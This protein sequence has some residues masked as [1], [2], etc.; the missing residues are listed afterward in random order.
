M[1]EIDERRVTELFEDIFIKEKIKPEKD[2]IIDFGAE[3]LGLK[4]ETI[5][6]KGLF[7][8]VRKMRL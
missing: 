2:P 7:V 4:G 6:K 1:K 8:H 3:L 5:S